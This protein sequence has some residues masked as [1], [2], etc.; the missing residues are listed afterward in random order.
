M[1]PDQPSFQCKTAEAGT[2]HGDHRSA[3]ESRSIKRYFFFRALARLSEDWC[4][5]LEDVRWSADPY[6]LRARVARMESGIRGDHRLLV[7]KL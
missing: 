2:L 5:L 7:E 6:Y 1:I 4:I 3:I